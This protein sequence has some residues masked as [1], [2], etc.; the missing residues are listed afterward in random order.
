VHV[1][2]TVLGRHAG[3]INYTVGQRRGIGAVGGAYGTPLYVVRLDAAT[4]QVV[5]GPRESLHTRWIGL[6]NVNW[7]GERPIPEEGLAVSVRV[8]STSPPQA[9]TLYPVDG[10]SVVLREGEYGIAAGQACAFY[11]DAGPHARLLGGGWINHTHREGVRLGR[12][13]GVP[14]PPIERARTQRREL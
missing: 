6:R 12:A 14:A 3:I 10:G 13:A 1:D 11:A 2:G 5:V 7:L 4:K 8:R 9:A